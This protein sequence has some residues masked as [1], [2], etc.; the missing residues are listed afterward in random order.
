MSISR[1]FI[2]AEQV[3]LRTKLIAHG[4]ADQID[5]TNA[6]VAAG[7]I[8]GAGI[9]AS[10]A[11]LNV[12]TG[13]VGG[14]STASKTL[15]L[16]TNKNTDVLALPVGGLAI[17]AGAGTPVTASAAELNTTTGELASA[18][19][20]TTPATG[21]CAVQLTLKDA[22]A[23]TLAHA[24]SGLLYASTSTGLA[25]AAATT[26]ATLVNGAILELVVGKVDLFISSTAGLLGFTLT[27]GTGD[28]YVTLVLPN[29]KIITTAAIH[30]N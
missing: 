8:L 21:S 28:Y 29:G 3:D 18:T 30:C 22:Q 7:I 16:G 12:N 9:T 2:T 6:S 20:A 23:V 1:T 19:M 5:V 24:V 15:V 25:I 13:V 27:A 17:G 11:E 26:I 10:A 4:L 14:T